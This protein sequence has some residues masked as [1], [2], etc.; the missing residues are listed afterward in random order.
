[1]DIKKNR[2][3]A[4]AG[5]FYPA[6]RNELEKSIAHHLFSPLPKKQKAIGIVS[7]HAG[8]IYSGDVAGAVYSRIEIPDTVVLIGPNHTGCGENIS[9][10]TNGTWS[11]PMGDV[12][13][14]EKLGVI[15]CEEASIV[16][17]V[18]VL[19]YNT[20]FVRWVFYISGF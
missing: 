12:P 7:P 16:H 9:V 14:D 11:M 3:P 13:I 15:V 19:I 4:V 20:P 8:F 10:M 18:W 1:M 5:K 6:N 2:A 17:A